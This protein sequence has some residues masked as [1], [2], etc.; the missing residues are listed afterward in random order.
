MQSRR[1][2]EEHI[3]QIYKKFEL[4][5]R[6]EAYTGLPAAIKGNAFSKATREENPR[7]A[8]S[9]SQCNKSKSYVTSFFHLLKIHS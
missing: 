5:L 6:T 7:F 1:D 4:L 2:G 3:Q 8:S 9:L